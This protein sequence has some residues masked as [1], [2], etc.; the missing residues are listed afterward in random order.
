[1]EKLR[2]EH[3]TYHEEQAV[4]AAIAVPVLA[5]AHRDL[6]VASIVQEVFHL[7][8]TLSPVAMLLAFYPLQG[9]RMRCLRLWPD[10]D[11]R[12]RWWR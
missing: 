10:A 5:A 4:V 11:L 2:E 12:R 9:V 6:A 1:M 3:E 7:E 8:E